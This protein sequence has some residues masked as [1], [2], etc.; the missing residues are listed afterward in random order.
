MTALVCFHQRLNSQFAVFLYTG[1]H[2][3]GGEGYMPWQQ[4]PLV[5][6][7]GNSNAARYMLQF[8]IFMGYITHLPAGQRAPFSKGN[9][10]TLT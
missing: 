7:S 5:F 10:N 3:L 2:S 6:I 9:Y 4:V 8:H 1:S